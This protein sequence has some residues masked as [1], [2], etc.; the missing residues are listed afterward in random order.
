MHPLMYNKTTL[1][2][3]ARQ[4]SE[5]FFKEFKHNQNFI[6][7]YSIFTHKTSVQADTLEIPP[8]QT[9]MPCLHYFT[10]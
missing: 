4:N 6:F 2:T 5:I 7:N 9:E 8:L 1:H 10:L 3:K